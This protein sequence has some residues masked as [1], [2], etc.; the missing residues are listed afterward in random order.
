[1]VDGYVYRLSCQD[2][3]STVPTK[4]T[5]INYFNDYRENWKEDTFVFDRYHPY[6]HLG[7]L[8]YR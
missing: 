7:S 5:Y 2:M 3:S 8:V 6:W 4:F 1:M